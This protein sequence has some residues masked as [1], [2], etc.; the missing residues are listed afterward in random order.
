MSGK[1]KRAA[2]TTETLTSA[3]KR[4]RI[5]PLVVDENLQVNKVNVD[6]KEDSFTVAIN[7]QSSFRLKGFQEL[8]YDAVKLGSPFINVSV[9]LSGSEATKVRNCFSKVEKQL[10]KVHTSKKVGPKYWQEAEFD[11]RSPV[12]VESLSMRLK[13][14][15]T[16]Y[17]IY[18]Y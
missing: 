6:I 12:F 16:R 15:R 2:T 11:M 3:N 5:L 7:T 17:P 13:I 9:E 14:G 18:S 1:N 10:K 8:R 4:Q